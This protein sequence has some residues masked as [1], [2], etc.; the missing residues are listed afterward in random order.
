M[1]NAMLLLSITADVHSR[2]TKALRNLLLR[3]FKRRSFSILL[4]I[5]NISLNGLSTIFDCTMYPHNQKDIGSP[6]SGYIT[7]TYIIQQLIIL[8]KNERITIN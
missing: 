1:Q 7:G 5:I 4:F 2:V 6:S 8:T 3:L